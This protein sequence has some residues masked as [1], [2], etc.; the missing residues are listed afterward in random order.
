MIN[1]DGEIVPVLRAANA[2]ARLA[3]DAPTAMRV[4]L[5]RSPDLL[6]TDLTVCGMDACGFLCEVRSFQPPDVMPAIA[7]IDETANPGA[8]HDAGFQ[9]AIAKPISGAALVAHAKHWTSALLARRR[10]PRT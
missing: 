7:L 2:D 4:M 5:Q 8:A 10:V 3:C 6:M 9:A 1:D